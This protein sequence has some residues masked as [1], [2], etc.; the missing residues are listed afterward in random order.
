MRGARS[1][2]AAPIVTTRSARLGRFITSF[3]VAIAVYEGPQ[4]VVRAVSEAYRRIVGGRDIVGLRM[5]D[6][7]PEL[8][9][10]MDGVDVFALLDRVYATGEGLAG[11][12]MPSA[13]DADGD[14]VAEPH[15]V[16]FWY[17]P[18]RGDDG[19]VEG[20]VAVVLDV[21]QRALAEGDLRASE[22]RFRGL[23]A[24]SPVGIFRTDLEGNLV[25]A[26]PRLEAIGQVSARELRDRGWM[27]VVHPDDVDALATGFVAA[28]S[29]G[30]EY[31]H[32]Y[33][34]V[35]PD[36]TIRWV[37]GRSA[38]VRNQ[39]GLP[40]GTVG[41]LEDITAQREALAAAERA[42]DQTRRL[43]QL[44]AR[45]NEAAD[46]ERIADVIL[47]DG[48]AAAGAEAGS[49]ALLSHDAAGEPAHFTIIRTTG[50][51]QE[52]AERYRR[53]PVTPGRPLSE[54]ARQRR[55]I[56]VASP[57]EWRAQFPDATED[58]TELGFSAFVALPVVAGDRVIAGLS[59]SFRAPQRFDD[60]T[61]AFLGALVEQ[62]SL[63][64]ERARLQENERRLAERNRA[65]L[66]SIQDA[67]VALDRELRFTYVNGRAEALLRRSASEL[68]G[69]RIVDVLPQDATM[70][71]HA[72]FVQALATQRFLHVEE[73]RV[74]A[75]LWLEA[76]V[77]PAIDG[78]TVF[79]QDVSERRR[80][81]ESAELLAEAGRILGSSL[82]FGETLR[83]LTR[84]VVPRLADWCA[85]DLIA[86]PL[87]RAWPPVL[88]R[89][90]IEHRDPSRVALAVRLQ[91]DFPPDW[92]APAGIPRVIREGVPEFHPV[93]TDAT[94]AAIA[95][96]EEHLA[97]L[98]ALRISSVIVVPL[99]ARGHTV[100]A[101]T[102][103]MAES[104]RRYDADD[105]AVA[106][107]LASRAAIAVDNARLYRDAERARTEAEGA[108]QAK[109]QFLA[110]M[111]HELRTPLNAIAGYAQL[112][113]LG[114]HGPVTDAQS[115]ALSRIQRSQQHLLTLINDVLNFARLEAG[116]VEF[117]PRPVPVAA[118]LEELTS[119]FAPQA[120]ARDITLEVP[121]PPA[122]SVLADADKARQV[123]LNLLSN[124]VKFT[125]P[126]GRVTV[127]C[128]VGDQ[129]VAI[130][131][132]D[133]G[134]GVPPD[135][136]A[137]IFEPFV[138][139]ERALSSPKEGTGLG[140]AIS[141]DLA[142]G[143]GGELAVASG[144]TGGAVFTF[145]LPRA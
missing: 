115:L 89:V 100:G 111:S 21:T 101:L 20:I 10:S 72:A 117:H 1:S 46:M 64:L 74:A 102:M 88:E 55:T 107:R 67:F 73:T 68:L 70:P 45:L 60:L 24:A 84:A 61:R 86:D 125:E 12:D 51:R 143:L 77:Y 79:L 106:E 18:L 123:L 145:T 8:A 32:Q 82:D 132:S 93:L 92:S 5:R 75:S 69:Q 140:L 137:R 109:S 40:V 15:V 114:V 142:R 54:A 124:A 130:R 27:S 138:Q 19:A 134:I 65:I 105:L 71:F 116:R 66:E 118:L 98:R 63:A 47:Q 49:L 25:Y 131:V 94:L 119:F 28:I 113:E 97:L 83:A 110:T 87:A 23:S 91:H 44:T 133:T 90:A 120:E 43:Q 126:G 14:G 37:H 108:N 41:T 9:G 112:I 96:G 122:V 33:R 121:V 56:L 85:V 30:G 136:Q 39:E 29:S 57:D 36:G 3:P 26:N 50:Y 16:D 80:R 78:L 17:E 11:T 35:L 144:A 22:E 6:A 42:V 104:G 129:L 135:A 62:C 76:R 95:R 38:I 31:E 4:H 48:L 7:L 53:F 59:F 52:V 13:W 81:Q 34:L 2:V 128:D 99:V 58:L 141:R 103:L 139:L 127:T